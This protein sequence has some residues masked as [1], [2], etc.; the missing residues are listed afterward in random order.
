MYI[1]D[2]TLKNTPLSLSVQRKSAEEAEAVYKEVME[3]LTSGQSRVIE[4]TCDRQV[5][6]KIAVLSSEISA[7]QMAEKSGASASGKPPGFF[8]AVAAGE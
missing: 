3:A 2:V 5:G 1:V 7:V 4:L 8:A 6:K